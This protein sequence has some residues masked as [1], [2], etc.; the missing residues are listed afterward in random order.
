MYRQSFTLIV[1]RPYHLIFALLLVTGCSNVSKLQEVNPSADDFASALASEYL[2]YAQSEQEQ[3]RY[4]SANYYAGKGLEASSGKDVLPDA[5]EENP[6]N[7]SEEDLL[8]AYK[9]LTTLLTDDVK[10]A[11][12]LELARLQLLFDCWQQQAT[13][14][15]QGAIDTSCADE[16]K[17]A[18]IELQ[19]LAQQLVYSQVKYYPLSFRYNSTRLTSVSTRKLQQVVRHVSNLRDFIV[20]VHAGSA[21]GAK[22]Q[23]LQERR[24]K[25]V[26][27]ALRNAG[28]PEKRLR[29]YNEGDSKRVH[30]SLDNAKP[31]MVS[32]KKVMVIVKT[33]KKAPK[34]IGEQ[35]R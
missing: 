10:Q 8:A 21:M 27:W 6:S 26:Y 14:Y 24:R 2:S 35:S 33:P 29:E 19:T 22:Q 30:L 16:F 15:F 20:V 17:P 23:V 18:V 4:L 1:M 31:M 13:R 7:D 12:P 5:P 11:S 25:S 32:E 34:D 28:I 9:D 3:G